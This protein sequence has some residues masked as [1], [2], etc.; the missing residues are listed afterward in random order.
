[1]EPG[2]PK[3]ARKRDARRITYSTVSDDSAI[4]DAVLAVRGSSDESYP[5]PNSLDSQFEVSEEGPNLL[6]TE[7]AASS[8]GR[9]S[10]KTAIS[11]AYSLD[12][13]AIQRTRTSFFDGPFRTNPD[14][15]VETCEGIS[16]VAYHFHHTNTVGRGHEEEDV[17]AIRTPSPRHGRKI[18]AETHA[19]MMK[20]LLQADKT[21]FGCGGR[22]GRIF[23][24][25]RQYLK[26]FN[27][28]KVRSLLPSLH[29]SPKIQEDVAAFGVPAAPTDSGVWPDDSISQPLITRFEDKATERQTSSGSD[30]SAYSSESGMIHDDPVAEGSEFSWLFVFPLPLTTTAEDQA[31]FESTLRR[32][33]VSYVDILEDAFGSFMSKNA[34]KGAA[35]CELLYSKEEVEDS[36]TELAKK[37]RNS[38]W[39]HR[40]LSSRELSKDE[41]EKFTLT[42]AR[43]VTIELIL[44]YF[45]TFK[46]S[47][48]DYFKNASEKELR[49]SYYEAHCRSKSHIHVFKFTTEDKE[50]LYVCSRMSVMVAELHAEI[51]QYPLQLSKAGIEELEVKLSDPNTTPAFVQFERKFRKLF[52]MHEDAYDP[53]TS[54]VLRQTDRIRILYDKLTESL[55]LHKLEAAGLLSHSF[56]MHHERTVTELEKTWGTF[57]LIFSLKQPLQE[58]R[59][60]FGEEIAFYFLFL[61]ELVRASIGLG[62]VAFASYGWMLTNGMGYARPVLSMI[63]LVWYR[64]FTKK[65]QRTQALF[66]NQWGGDVHSVSTIKKLRN[67]RFRGTMLPAP[68]DENLKQAQVSRRSEIAG[69]TCSFLLSSAFVATLFIL[70]ALEHYVLFKTGL[71]DER[72]HEDLWQRGE[73]M[74]IGAFF[75]MQIRVVDAIWNRMSDWITDLEFRY[76][77]EDFDWSKRVKASFVRSLTSLFTV[78]FSAFAQPALVMFSSSDIQRLEANGS[79]GTRR[80]EA[81]IEHQRVLLERQLFSIFLMRYFLLYGAVNDVLTPWIKMTMQKQREM[82]YVEQQVEMATYGNY[83]L[84]NDYLDAIIPLGFVTFFGMIYPPSVLLLIVVLMFRVRADSWKLLFAHRRPYPHVAK[85]IG[86][87][88]SMLG[89]FAYGMVLTNLGLIMVDFGGIAQLFHVRFN[90]LYITIFGFPVRTIW[91]LDTLIFLAMALAISLMWHLLE[92]ILDDTSHYVRTEQQRQDL[93]RHILSYTGFKGVDLRRVALMKDR[94]MARVNFSSVMTYKEAA[95]RQHHL[96]SGPSWFDS[97]NVLGSMGFLG[98]WRLASL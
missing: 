40:H 98:N 92:F 2:S 81:Q 14:S 16:A 90:P 89:L 10:E 37:R 55:N 19:E 34:I 41:V 9:H 78:M 84:T 23:S 21:Q 39:T 8:T 72:K 54:S 86:V 3:I 38:A 57:R 83:E 94:L 6:A 95:A 25:G 79:L 69:R 97:S 47:C 70:V 61:H 66:S 62:V 56:P 80:T 11:S 60:Y 91:V 63:I 64:V 75:G 52:Q 22:S 4:Q 15:H 87:F 46:K 50:S 59:N 74:L 93:Q 67:R 96:S 58:I 24:S 18:T 20:S 31:K 12:Q 85:D 73:H 53:K 48:E 36:L 44:A 5:I 17:E 35:S 76:Y 51:E 68:D 30:H 49:R 13:P 42:K 88:N 28:P 45:H 26:R 43:Q 27:M 82:S 65:W 29:R 7:S 33:N 32:E 71:N 1:M 77:E